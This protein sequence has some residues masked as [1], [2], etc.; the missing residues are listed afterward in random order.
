METAKNK[1]KKL[2][3]TMFDLGTM[4]YEDA[5]NCSLQTCNEV[6]NE[7]HDGSAFWETVRKEVESLRKYISVKE[8]HKPIRSDEEIK[9]LA[10]NYNTNIRVSSNSINKLTDVARVNGYF[11]GYKQCQQDFIENKR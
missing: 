1:A 10:R 3:D 11:K 9:E 5:V 8:K 6:L 2:V 4:N 7:K